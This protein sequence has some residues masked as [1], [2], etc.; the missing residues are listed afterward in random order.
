MLSYVL[1]TSL[2]AANAPEAKAKL[3]QTKD[4]MRTI[5]NEKATVETKQKE[6]KKLTGELLDFSDVAEQTLGESYQKLNAKQKKEF[7][8]SLEQLVEASYISRINEANTSDIKFTEATDAGEAAV[9]KATADTQGSEV[10]L[11]FKLMPRAQG[12]LVKDVV[13][14]DV[15]LVRNYRSQFQ[16]QL[17]KGTVADLQK[18]I[19]KKVAEM[20]TDK[21][22]T[23]KKEGQL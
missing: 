15:S 2:I 9:V 11:E 3:E 5:A 17:A 6:M 22:A 1:M 10:H 7:A 18:K 19:Q 4:R 21:A 14:D 8:S 16:K 13:I 12:W 23:V 20:R